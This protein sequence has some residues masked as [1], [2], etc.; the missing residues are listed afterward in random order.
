MVV[1]IWKK[2][3]NRKKTWLGLGKIV[4]WWMWFHVIYDIM[5]TRKG[6]KDIWNQGQRRRQKLYSGA[7]VLSRILVLSSYVKLIELEDPNQLIH[8]KIVILLANFPFSLPILIVYYSYVEAYFE[9]QI[10]PVC[11]KDSIHRKIRHL[12]DFFIDPLLPWR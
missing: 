3:E 12:Y 6:H 8:W 9:L 11:K 4:Y 5:Q 1:A 2:G 10:E 7:L